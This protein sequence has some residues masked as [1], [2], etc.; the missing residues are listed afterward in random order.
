M[1]EELLKKGYTE[2]GEIFENY[3]YYNIG[4]T[5][6]N[7]LKKFKI[8]PN[9][10]YKEYKF[11]KP[12]G[13]LVD[14]RNKEKIIVIAVIEHKNF[15]EFDTPQKKEKACKQCNDYCEVLD[16]KIG[17]ITDMEEF[18]WINPQKDTNNAEIIYYDT[19]EIKM[20]FDFI[21]KEDGYILSNA[22]ILNDK[23][24]TETKKTLKLIE[25]VLKSIGSDY[26]KLKEEKKLNPSN[27]ARQVWQAIWLAS[28]ENPDKCLAT[29]VELFL[30]KFL[31]DLEVLVKNKSGTPISFS[32]VISSGKNLCLK[33]YFTNTRTYIKEIFPV[34]EKDNTSVINDFILDPEIKEHNT[35]FYNM[36]MKFK[37]FLKRN[38]YYD[39]LESI[40]PEFKTRLYEDFLKRSASQKNWG[41]FF[42]PRNVVKAIIE[43]SDIEHLPD[44]SKV[45]DPACGVGGFILEPILTKRTSDYYFE[46]DKLKRKIEYFG[47]DRDP[48]TT[49]LG[50]ANMLIYLS[51]LLKDNPTLTREFADTINKT[52]YSCHHSI[53]GSLSIMSR[54][55][56]DLVMTNPPYVTKG[57]VNYKNAIKEN[58][59]L[60][61]FY[62]INV[63]GTEGFFLQKIIRE[64][65][66]KKRAFVIVPD[67]TLNRLNDANIRNII[68]DNCI[69]DG[70]ISLPQGTF[71]ATLRK[72]Y[73][74]CL[75]KK[76][77][78]EVKQTD[79]VF[80][81]LISNIGESLDVY[82]AEIPEN[83]LK[84]MAKQFKYFMTD[85]NIFKPFN[86][87]CK[88]FG[89]DKFDPEL[90]WCVDRWW[91]HEEKI[92]LEIEEKREVMNIDE[93]YLEIRSI[94]E[95]ID[96]V[97][98][99]INDLRSFTV[100]TDETTNFKNEKLTSL[101]KI[102]QG[103]AFYTKK[104]IIENKWKGDVP[105]Y[106]SNTK[107][108]GLLIKID[109]KEIKR[110]DKYYKYCLTWAIDGDAGAIFVR[111]PENKDNKRE[112]EFL[113]IINNHC[114][115]LI[116]KKIKIDLEYIK[117]V[118]QPMFYQKRKCYNNKKLGTN[119]IIDMEIPIP[120]KEDG[121]YD[122]N[123]Q[124][125]IAEKYKKLESIKNSM[126]TR[127]KELNSVEVSLD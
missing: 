103:N 101:F 9:K 73:I 68:K 84:D 93:F 21:L 49:I 124:R 86:I 26:S 60:N 10:N 25:K 35:L 85:K 89:I 115:I 114:G 16:A 29:F 81:Y 13:L 87:R 125:E 97:M 109:E 83:D 113:F 94:K 57:I 52:F 96:K 79:P 88:I 39:K 4:N 82:R 55:T 7:D 92:K 53:L 56:Y 2:H 51:D 70:I 102:G 20:G 33:Y 8:I 6:L 69:I 30:F 28:G 74:L 15:S 17:I 66:P 75:T 47:F 126:I 46:Y 99:E 50:K 121:S 12:D 71:Y 42:T 112:K 43:I 5:S 64:L 40:E 62:N 24:K 36:L 123:K 122:L 76:E 127:F 37:E 54:N 105:V 58:S 38:H 3:E 117:I 63:M 107:N 44:G 95:E 118:L 27:L 23:N 34:N 110:E 108:N 14:R 98:N 65:K 90:H 31:S 100:A 67:G 18:V 61:R 22:F 106:S 77:E 72:T 80:T 32:D 78:I 45:C 119:Q 19:F 111:N 120:I 104:R 91:T 59:T 41:Q 116:P 1:S 48:K 11:K